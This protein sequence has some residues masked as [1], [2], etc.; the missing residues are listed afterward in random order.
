MKQ[1]I[2]NL[3]VVNDTAERSIAL[4]TN[5]NYTLSNDEDEKQKIINIVEDHR[6]RVPNASKNALSI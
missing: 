3:K 5:L 2:D 6:R 4:F 1:I